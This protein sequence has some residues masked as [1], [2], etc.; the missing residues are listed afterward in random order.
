MTPKNYLKHFHYRFEQPHSLVW[1]KLYSGGRK[2]RKLL[3]LVKNGQ[4]DALLASKWP[5]NPKWSIV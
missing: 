2:A 3:K 5:R 1:L 4:N